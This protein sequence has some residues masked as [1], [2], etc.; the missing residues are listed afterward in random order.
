MRNEN[1]RGIVLMLL[2]M[3]VLALMDAL[4]IIHRERKPTS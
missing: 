2:A 3:A 4:Y 1:L